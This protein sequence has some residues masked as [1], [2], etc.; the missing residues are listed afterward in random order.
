MSGELAN[1]REVPEPALAQFS[2]YTHEA[3]VED[4]EALLRHAVEVFRTAAAGPDGEKKAKAV[5][6]PAKR[7]L[8]ARL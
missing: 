6:R 7:L 2:G 3:K 8:T 4:V 5:H 1:S